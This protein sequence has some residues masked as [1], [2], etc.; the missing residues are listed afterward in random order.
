MGRLV[1]LLK[2]QLLGAFGIGRLLNERDP[3]SRRKLAL[4]A[5]GVALLAALAAGY[6]WVLG[7][8][9]ASVGV[10]GSLPAI[11]VVASGIGCAFSTLAK[12]NGLLFGFKDF[13]LVVTMPV[14]LWA[15]AVS[16]TAPLYG[17]GLALSLL[18]GGPLMASWLVSTGAGAGETAAAALV[19]LLAP[20][21][22]VA[23][24]VVLSFCVAWAAARTPFA[25]R[26]LGIAGVAVTAA[27]VVGV[28]TAMGGMDPHRF[29]G[30]QS[31]TSL[32][33]WAKDTLGTFWPPAAWASDAVGGDLT[34]LALYAGVS[35]MAF[36]TVTV[37]L[38][39]LLV[40]L[41]APLSGGARK[42][43]RLQAKAGRTHRP[44]TAL[45]AKELRL[46][47]ATP[48]YLM[49]TAVG[50]VLALTASIATAVASPQVLA[51]TVN[52]PGIDR[53]AITGLTA[54]AIPWVL[55]LFMSM[56]SLTA[57]ST[58]LEGAARWIAQTAPVPTPVLVG[59]KIVANLV[60]T[61]P[62][63]LV[64]GGIAAFTLAKGP[65]D[66]VLF[67]AA[68]VAGSLLSSCLGALFDARKPNFDWASVYEP[69]KRSASVA[70]CVGL[71]FASVSAGGAATLC[72]GPAAG[73][74]VAACL[75]AVA[76]LAGKT[77][78]SIPLQDR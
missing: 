9:L 78:A 59:S 39:R 48:A 31:L 34:A 69:V 29:D 50:P 72:F 25:N 74:A 24:A 46:W 70:I 18:T 56:T 28:A 19:L 75:I 23:L 47:V 66:A 54:G 10:A 38:A 62:T 44:L 6:A 45:V 40:P 3:R 77:A 4:A 51:G 60:V 71:G 61:V 20:A 76:A 30:P 63:A 36:A 1:P 27:I 26:M 53:A 8:S 15:V 12:A 22:P 73:L 11:A 17:M 5:A 55:A 37:A 2:V 65:L 14:P 49:N 58:S 42:G 13:D 33:V 7:G 68:P 57:S 32:G 52:V 67:V 64:A 43:R 35:A 16:R 21:F 41:N